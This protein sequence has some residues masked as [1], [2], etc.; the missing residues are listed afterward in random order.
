M[1]VYNGLKGIKWEYGDIVVTEDNKRWLVTD[2]IGCSPI[3][4]DGIMKIKPLD[5]SNRKWN[6]EVRNCV[7][8]EWIDGA[9]VI[10]QLSIH[11]TLKEGQ[12]VE[13]IR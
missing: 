10:Y 9:R 1:K 5:G 6:H 3:Y 13:I 2:E 4:P 11:A 7:V 12:K 8:N